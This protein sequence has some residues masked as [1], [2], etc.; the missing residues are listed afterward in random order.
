VLNMIDKYLEE[1]LNRQRSYLI[2]S[3]HIAESR[4]VLASTEQIMTDIPNLCILLNFST[5]ILEN[6]MNKSVYASEEVLSIL[7]SCNYFS[8]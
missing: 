4:I 5:Q 8:F 1:I 7:P 6:S 2:I 3:D